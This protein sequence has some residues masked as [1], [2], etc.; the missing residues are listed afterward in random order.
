MADDEELPFLFTE[1]VLTRDKNG[2]IFL[3]QNNYLQ[4]LKLLSEGATFC[5]IA[6]V[7]IKLLCLAHSRPNGFFKVSQLTQLTK[8]LFEVNRRTII[9]RS[10]KLIIYSKAN[11]VC[12]RFVKLD[13]F[14]IRLIGFTDVLLAGNQGFTLQLGYI[15]IISDK[16]SSVIP[17]LYKSYKA[18]CVTLSVTGA[19]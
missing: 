19:E 3:H 17:M 11:K 7:K 15:L 5:F 14:L 6:F 2:F 1:F 10:N 4:K 16:S 9:K 8:E 13:P 12:I 18:R